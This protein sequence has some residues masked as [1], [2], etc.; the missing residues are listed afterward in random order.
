MTVTPVDT[1]QHCSPISQT[2]EPPSGVYFK[3]ENN[4]G[5]MGPELEKLEPSSAGTGLETPGQQCPPNEGVWETGRITANGFFD[6]GRGFK[7]KGKYFVKHG[8]GDKNGNGCRHLFDS[9]YP[10]K[11]KAQDIQRTEQA[12]RPRW[13]KREGT[14]LGRGCNSTFFFWGELEGSLLAFCLCFV[15]CLC[16][17][18]LFLKLFFSSQVMTSQKDMR[19]DASQG[20]SQSRIKSLMYATGGQTFSR[21]SPF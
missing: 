16:C 3:L 5:E 13:E 12:V 15:F 1:V 20:S 4:E 18:C 2:P 8:T 19:G 11:T 7:Q 9:C 14:A 17:V 10:V 6:R 21:P